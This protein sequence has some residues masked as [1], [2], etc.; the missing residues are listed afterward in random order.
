[1]DSETHVNQSE[2]S[3]PVTGAT[4]SAQ[5]DLESTA[6][7]FDGNSGSEA[8]S[9]DA[10]TSWNPRIWG[11]QEDRLTDQGDRLPEQTLTVSLVVK[12]G[13]RCCHRLD[14]TGRGI[15]KFIV[16]SGLY[17]DFETVR[18]DWT[19]AALPSANTWQQLEDAL[20]SHNTETKM[21]EGEIR[22]LMEAA[23]S[24]PNGD[25]QWE[26]F[27]RLYE[28]QDQLYEIKYQRKVQR[29][30]LERLGRETGCPAS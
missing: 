30:E 6:A 26:E 28:R 4:S 7:T 11:I 13:Q 18:N 2:N 12:C 9:I 19:E 16:V 10:S 5:T 24:A 21:R 27:T 14:M 29:R 8:E 20:W 15:V 3:L 23:E 25:H 1:M 17:I 22:A